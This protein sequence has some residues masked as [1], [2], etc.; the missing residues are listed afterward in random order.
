MSQFELE[1]FARMWRAEKSLRIIYFKFIIKST[2][3]KV[4]VM[5]VHHRK[6]FFSDLL[7][8]GLPN[9]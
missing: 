7:G 1:L 6:Q 4:I 5:N 2:Q 3:N 8:E 9:F